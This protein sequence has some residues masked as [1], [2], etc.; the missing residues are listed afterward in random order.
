VN[1]AI[2]IRRMAPRDAAFM[3]RMMGDASVYPG[4][5]QL[6]FPSE[7]GW[8]ERVAQAPTPGSAELQ[9]VAERDGEPLGSLGLHPVGLHVRRRHV[10]MLG[11]SVIGSAQGQ[12]V[13]SALMQAALDYADRWAQLLR[14]ELN[15]YTDNHRA[16]ALYRRFGFELEG[17]HKAY[18]LRDGAYVDSHSMARLHPNPPTVRTP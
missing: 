18:A 14:I 16:I 9:I 3:A 1:G 5:M 8:A 2:V 7:S 12:G 6:P 17:T 11:I 4:L 10:A 15:V 13:G